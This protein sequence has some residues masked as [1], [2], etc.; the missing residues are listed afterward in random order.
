[1]MPAVS[2]VV[3]IYNAEKYLENCIYSIINQTFIDMQILLIDDGST[4]RSG[5]I[6]DNY[7]QWDTRILVFHMRNAV[8][9]KLHTHIEP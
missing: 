4:D 8:S 9:G 6:C 5:E 7:A 3:P 1:M 2:I